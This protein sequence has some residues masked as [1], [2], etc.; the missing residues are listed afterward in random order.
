MKCIVTTP[1]PPEKE[2]KMTEYQ[3]PAGFQERSSDVVG[4]WKPE[5]GPIQFVPRG[6]FLMDNT[7]K[8]T[9]VSIL[10]IGN[11]TKETVI[12]DAED[13][14]ERKG[15]IGDVVGVW[16][17]PGMKDIYSLGGVEVF[18]LENGEK[19]VG[20]PSPMKKYVVASAKLGSPI[21]VLADRRRDSLT[22]ETPWTSKTDGSAQPKPGS[23]QPKPDSAQPKPDTSQSAGDDVIP[24]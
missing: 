23:A 9:N 6:A 22:V 11:L 24:L 12:A 10:L 20:K 16:Y 3:L 4:F 8:S 14:S 1:T 2:T 15:R 13:D 17:K 5:K 19:D 7:L 21:P 18:M